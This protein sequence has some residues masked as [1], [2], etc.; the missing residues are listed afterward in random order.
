MKFLPPSHDTLPYRITDALI[1]IAFVGV[2]I[3]LIGGWL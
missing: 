3:A 1:A 2:V